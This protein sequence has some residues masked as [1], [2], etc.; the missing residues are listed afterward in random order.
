[1]M[2]F[3]ILFIISSLRSPPNFKDPPRILAIRIY[4]MLTGADL[5]TAKDF[6]DHVE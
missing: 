6:I 3:L 5:R 2:K 4:R 1:M